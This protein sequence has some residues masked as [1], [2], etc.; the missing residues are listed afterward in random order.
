MIAEIA[1][2]ARV[3]ELDDTGRIASSI[4]LTLVSF[5]VCKTTRRVICSFAAE[6][7]GTAASTFA[8]PFP[9]SC[10]HIRCC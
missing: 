9:L 4:S 6:V 7:D 10:D 2:I 5:A 3:D 8:F 1:E